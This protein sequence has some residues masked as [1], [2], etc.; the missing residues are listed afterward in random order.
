M[1]KD[2]NKQ[3]HIFIGVSWPY[4]S[5]SLHIGHLAGQYVVCDI[6]ARYNRLKGNKVLM[7]S[8]SDSHGAPI[9][10]AAREKKLSPKQL[11]ENSHKELVETYKALNFL[12]DNYTSTMTE[13][14]KTVVQNIFKILY[15]NN[16]LFKQKSTQYYD[17]E[18]KRFLPD[19][20][21]KG[22]CPKCN[23]DN[24]R[25]DECPE[26][27]EFLTP[28]DLVNPYSTLSDAKPV[29]RKTEHFYMDLSKTQKKLK[30]WINT[31]S[32]NWRKWVSTSTNGFLKS[33]LQPRPVTRDL[34]FGIPVPMEGWEGKCIYVWI[35]AVVGYLSASIEWAGDSSKWEDF[36]KNPK[37]KHYYFVAG[38]NVPY[39]TIMWPA[40]LIA[41]NEKY[42]HEE[43]FK[44]FLLPNETL[45][46]PLNL[47][48]DVP[49]N[50]IL[51]YKGKKMSKG[52][53]NTIE[54]STLLQ[55]YGADILRYF[56]TKYAPENHDREFLWKDL[57]D[58]NNNEL[59]ANLGN[60]I[61]RV[62]TFT[63]TKFDGIVPDGELS[64]EVEEAINTTF[65]KVGKALENCEFV[66]AMD[67]VL[68]L[69]HFANKYF[70]DQEPWAEINDNLTHAEN[71]IFNSIQIVNALRVLLKPFLP[72]ASERLTELLNIPEEYDPNEELRDKGKV[73]NF[74]NS[75]IFAEIPSE[76]RINEPQII[77]QKLEYTEDLKNQDESNIKETD[78]SRG[79]DVKITVDENLSHI[80][81][82]SKSFNNLVVKKKDPK[83]K[84]WL[85]DLIEKVEKKYS[86]ENWQKKEIF[87]KYVD[88]HNQF[89]KKQNIP[90][91]SQT[92]VEMVKEK[93]RLPNINTLVD[94]YN[95]VS[96]LTGI[97][98][99]AHDIAKIE[100]DIR[101]EKTKNGYAYSDEKGVICHL[102]T[103]Q[104][105]RT[106]INHKTTDALLILQ[107]HETLGEEEL[108]KTIRLLEEGIELITKK[109]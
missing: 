25:G 40:E 26:C 90:S 67:L 1:N 17:P 48:F 57:I 2:F 89:S 108:E 103:K 50:K 102:D 3:K 78:V 51:L 56:C 12:Y 16:F 31:N 99:G 44:Q 38:G 52:D 98:I 73:E 41:Y 106:K 76:H 27:G 32:K 34:Q 9:E 10:L 97:S 72:S 86:E 65:T 23:T 36:W 77:F 11:A 91:S 15:E 66:K 5:G 37:C 59:V 94:I 105:D 8:G 61:N 28:E 4:A 93:G 96:A 85:K 14:H 87:T 46:K 6:F 49:A 19:R 30:D 54:V 62:L 107:G 35:E 63:T 21:V 84:K 92:L 68:K 64:E 71:T 104:C 69:G 109:S 80:P 39:H 45:Q 74:L 24:A 13:N 75:W 101:F 79:R 22:T 88:L 47:P 29:L 42:E 55:R 81:L 33:G 20:Y 43:Q 83:V 95:A 100:G 7:V 60:F 18:V 53:K 58:A 82:L 70:N